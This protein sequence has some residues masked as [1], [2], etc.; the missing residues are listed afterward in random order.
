[1][2]DGTL[3]AARRPCGS[4]AFWAA[5]CSQR[6]RH[7]LRE[8]SNGSWL[9]RLASVICLGRRRGVLALR[10]A[11]GGATAQRRF[12]ATRERINPHGDDPLLALLPRSRGA[13]IPSGF[14]GI[15]PVT[16]GPAICLLC[17]PGLTLQPSGCCAARRAPPTG[18][19]ETHASAPHLARLNTEQR[20]R[21]LV[22]AQ[23]S[24]G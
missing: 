2:S 22:G 14:G 9:D 12:H 19:P 10:C 1:M 4:G 3:R 16:T 24:S 21:R 23:A 7:S 11:R 15:Y 17:D 13:V 20:L 18:T 8:A 6:D 5:E